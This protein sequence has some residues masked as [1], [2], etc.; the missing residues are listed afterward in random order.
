MIARLAARQSETVSAAFADPHRRGS[1][2]FSSTRSALLVCHSRRELAFAVAFLSVFPAGNLL[3]FKMQVQHSP[4]CEDVADG[5][6]L[7]SPFVGR[8]LSDSDPV[9][10]AF[11]SG[12]YSRRTETGAW[13]G[14]RPFRI[15][16]NEGEN[17]KTFPP[18]MV[19]QPAVF[20][21][22]D[23]SSWQTPPESA[24]SR[25]PAQSVPAPVADPGCRPARAARLSPTPQRPVLRGR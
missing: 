4:I 23:R 5:K 18:P 25:S 8:A 3:R 1:A 22:S 7:Q 15:A 20:P 6:N 2:K 13:A 12:G 14:H 21:A 24:G 9:V 11:Q 10:D 17:R 16:G 19:P